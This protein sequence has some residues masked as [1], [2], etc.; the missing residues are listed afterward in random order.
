M[1]V[2]AKSKDFLSISPHNPINSFQF[3]YTLDSGQ[4][5]EREMLLQ[6]LVLAKAGGGC[7]LSKLIYSHQ[8]RSTILIRS[9]VFLKRNLIAG[10]CFKLRRS[11]PDSE[12]VR[13]VLPLMGCGRAE[14]RKRLLKLI[15]LRFSDYIQYSIASYSRCCKLQGHYCLLILDMDMDF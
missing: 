4:G 1:C 2:F 14:P 10:P 13:N 12:E 11:S 8:L 6:R 7:I 9:V 15:A 5:K 3:L